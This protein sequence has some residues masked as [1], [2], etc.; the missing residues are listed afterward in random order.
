M[1]AGEMCKLALEKDVMIK[2][3]V[4]A[5]S[6]C[7]DTNIDDEDTLRDVAEYIHTEL[8]T[9]HRESMARRRR[10]KSNWANYNAKRAANKDQPA[11][12]EV[13]VELLKVKQE[14]VKPLKVKRL[15]LKWF[16]TA[17][18]HLKQCNVIACAFAFGL[19]SKGFLHH[20]VCGLGQV[21]KWCL[22]D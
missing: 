1:A 8:K 22:I 11:K 10:G 14:P 13:K 17:Q 16:G 3:I 2:T 7:V 20:G 6:C 4:A 12:Q 18:P 19:Y 9:V 21:V 15:L 5:L